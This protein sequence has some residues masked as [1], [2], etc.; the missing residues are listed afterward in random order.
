MNKRIKPAKYRV[1]GWKGAFDNLLV[2]DNSSEDSKK[3][4]KIFLPVGKM[5]EAIEIGIPLAKAHGEKMLAQKSKCC[6]KIV[7]Y[8][9]CTRAST[10][11]AP[12]E[13]NKYQRLEKVG[14]NPWSG[15][16]KGKK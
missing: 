4:G 5:P 15:E 12:I 1:G 7:L 9:K 11:A 6:T 13:C 2:A 10:A 8:L 16:R 3:L 14:K